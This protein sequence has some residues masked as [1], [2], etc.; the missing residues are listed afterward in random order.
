MLAT[1][2]YVAALLNAVQSTNNKYTCT[3]GINWEYASHS[4][5]ILDKK[6]PQVLH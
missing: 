6:L 2:N 4:R 5:E 1:V 3:Y